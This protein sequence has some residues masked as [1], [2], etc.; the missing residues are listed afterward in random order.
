[1]KII[2]CII[3]IFF[4]LQDGFASPKNGNIPRKETLY[5]N[6]TIGKFQKNDTVTLKVWDH[7][8]GKP[9]LSPHKK[10]IAILDS[11]G[12]CH[13]R[14]ENIV[15]FVYFSLGHGEVDSKRFQPYFNYYL[16]QP[17]DNINIKITNANQ[18]LPDEKSI[19]FSG[20]NATAYTFQRDIKTIEQK[21]T[22]SL[23]K[24]NKN[25]SY[26]FKDSIEYQRYYAGKL[27]SLNWAINRVF[28][29]DSVQLSYLN[30]IRRRISQAFF[31]RLYFDV[32]GTNHR[33]LCNGYQGVYSSI[34]KFISIQAKDS[35][36]KTMKSFYTKNIK[37]L[38]EL[39]L[40]RNAYKSFWYVDYLIKKELLTVDYDFD[41]AFKLLS[42]R[43][44][45]KI[46]DQLLVT[47]LSD[48]YQTIPSVQTLMN[49]ALRLVKSDF[50]IAQLLELDNL[51]S[52]GKSAYVFNLPDKNGHLYSLDKL[53]GK[54]VFLDFWYVG[55]GPCMQ[56]FKTDVQNAEEFYL[57][58]PDV[59]FI[60]ICLYTNWD[61]WQKTLTSKNGVYTS[62]NAINLIA[63]GAKGD[64]IAQKYMVRGAPRPILIGK[65]GRIFCNNV[66]ELRDNINGNML[67][68]SI[69]NAMLETK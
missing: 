50:A 59:T 69:K 42:T 63:E 12:V 55:C 24:K 20:T 32:V 66:R 7:I 57:N 56:Y 37:K 13:F 26:D 67:I 35:L 51:S 2:V 64:F 65:D 46:R 62:D 4:L 34:N 27:P 10:I 61:A 15:D 68:Q 29:L 39:P 11:N 1:M 45:G 6:I 44:F 21:I 16:A 36:R 19:F 53:K 23:M 47:F 33:G 58:N 48:Y 30:S 28:H 41:D 60:T 38:I 18:K 14:V 9:E 8:F 40:D 49:R 54:V 5:I 25:V 43:Y 17:G 31:D 52:K 3:Y 22:D